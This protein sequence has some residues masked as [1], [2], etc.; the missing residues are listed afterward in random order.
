MSKNRPKNFYR[1][2][3]DHIATAA[4]SFVIGAL[5]AVAAYANFSE[6]KKEYADRRVLCADLYDQL[7]HVR[8]TRI[9]AV[10]ELEKLKLYD[11][12]KMVESAGIAKFDKIYAE[13]N[14]NNCSEFYK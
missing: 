9:S 10:E 5:I 11:T 12:A 4:V 3:F 6:S 8:N 14:S 7:Q 1:K 13:V 2:N